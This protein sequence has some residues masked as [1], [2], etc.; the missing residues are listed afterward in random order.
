MTGSPDPASPR[1]G[2]GLTRLDHV[3]FVIPDLARPSRVLELRG[4]E[5][6]PVVEYP[7]EGTRERY[8]GPEGVSGRVLLLQ[9]IA[10]GPYLRALRRRGPGLHHLAI[11]VRDV[12]A[13]VA[14][15]AGSGW[16]LHPV[17]L[18]T[19]R[20][21]RTAWLARPDA[22]T[23]IELVE[24]TAVAPVPVAARITVPASVTR[25]GLFT[26]LGCPEIDESTGS[27]PVLRLGDDSLSLSEIL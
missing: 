12:E 16:Y 1:S 9:P 21:H 5:P 25:P 23:L 14:G 3:A 17:S 26:A 24:G 15:L 27:D 20:D 11:E 22:A 2:P 6:G 10:D 4:L 7:S 18:A 8:L 19:V 13:A